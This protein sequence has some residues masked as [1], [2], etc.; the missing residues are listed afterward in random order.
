MPTAVPVR[1][2]AT[3]A[4]SVAGRTADHQTRPGLGTLGEPGEVGFA[5]L[6]VCVPAFLGL[7]AQVVEERRVARQ[8]LD[9]GE[10]IVRRVEPGL[11]HAQREWAELEHAPA[12]RDGFSLEVGERDDLVDQ[13][14]RERLLRVVLLAQEPD[15]ARLLLTNDPRQQTRAIAA[16]EAA[17]T[18]AGLSEPR[19]VGGNGQVADNVQDMAAPDRVAR[20][21]CDNGLRETA[22]LDLQVE[23]VRRPVPEAST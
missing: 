4:A 3:D 17:D 7:F 15:L 19:V 2:G 22:D 21:H 13:A 5:F 20:D 12:P 10:A 18:R 16:V 9:S 1:T 8:L 6:D 11:E 23:D 14:H